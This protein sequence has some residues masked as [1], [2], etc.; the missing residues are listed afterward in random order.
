MVTG[1]G[2]VAA[3]VGGVASMNVTV[4]SSAV[5]VVG[6]APVAVQ[7]PK[8]IANA[9]ITALRIETSSLSGG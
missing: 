4:V 8:A 5:V 7:A 2:A 6:V 9:M 1:N 3:V